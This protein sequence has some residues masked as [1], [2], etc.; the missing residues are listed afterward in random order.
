MVMVLL[1]HRWRDKGVHAFLDGIS[2]K[3]VLIA[4]FYLGNAEYLF[5]AIAPRSSLTGSGSTW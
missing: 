2:S 5:I 3:W 4:Q 1:T